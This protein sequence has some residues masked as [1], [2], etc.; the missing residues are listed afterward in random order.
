MSPRRS[1]LVIDRS[2]ETG[3]VLRTAL[4]D[5]NTDVIEAISAR[6]G[7]ELARCHRPDVIVLDAELEATCGDGWS[8][9]FA[10]ETY[11]RDSQLVL[12]GSARR[13]R[14]SFPGGQFLAKPYHYGALVRKIEVLLSRGPQSPVGERTAN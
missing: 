14:E 2:E 4:A 1:V 13:M 8:A 6:Q 10:A 5:A 3:E 11:G 7:L 12:L 9:H